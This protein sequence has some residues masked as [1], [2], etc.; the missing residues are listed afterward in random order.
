MR[1]KYG[2]KIGI[3][4]AWIYTLVLSF[5]WVSS[6]PQSEDTIPQRIFYFLWF[7]MYGLPIGGILGAISGI[8]S[9][10]II[11]HL[12]VRYACTL[13]NHSWIIG[14]FTCSI[15]WLVIHLTVGRFLLITGE[16]ESIRLYWIFIGYPGI[17]YVMAGSLL[18][19]HYRK[20][21]DK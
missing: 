1:L 19:Q 9:G 10:F 13:R 18:S 21:I 7:L 8:V 11:Y 14:F 2:A 17:I 16:R 5:I 4:L 6:P 3:V 15:F 20:L 12:L